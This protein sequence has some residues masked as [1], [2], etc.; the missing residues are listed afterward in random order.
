VAEDTIIAALADLAPSKGPMKSTCAWLQTATPDQIESI[1]AALA[2][3]NTY[4]A[5]GNAMRA[6]GAKVTL[7]GIRDHITAECATCRISL[8][9]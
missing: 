1:R 3:G 9:P 5:V 8:K 6:A 7:P 4:T 2:R